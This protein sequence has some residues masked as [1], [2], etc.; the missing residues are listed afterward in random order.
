[1]NYRRLWRRR[2][3]QP[4][5]PLWRSLLDIGIFVFAAVVVLLAIRIFNQVTLTPG[6][7]DVIDGDSFRLGKDEIRLN[8]IDAPE[9]RQVCRDGSD[10]QWN[11]GRAATDALRRL[12]TGREVGCTGL[13]ADRYGRLVSRCTAGR[14][15][16]N[17][18]MVRLGW[19]IAYTRHSDDYVDQE[20]EARRQRRGIWRGSFDLPE[21]WREIHRPHFDRA[22]HD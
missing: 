12:V 9:Y 20:A 5:R 17:A 15:D 6:T 13:D 2:P 3:S 22:P 21:D 14:I 16:L 19:A 11:C 7:A 4:P 8:G 1:M 18:E 10:R